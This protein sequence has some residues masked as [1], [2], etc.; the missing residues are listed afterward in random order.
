MANYTF[1]DNSDIVLRK[2]GTNSRSAMD[3]AA[4]IMVE[5]IQEKI[6]YGYHDVHGNPPHTEIVETGR[7]FDSIKA[8][9]RRT[10]QNAYVTEAGTDVPHAIYVHDGHAGHS[11]K[12]K[13]GSWITVKGGHTPGRPF[14]TDGILAAQPELKEILSDELKQGFGK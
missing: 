14:I 1:Q 12:L 4:E 7:L 10:S 6:L 3:K 11:I 9:V 5:S 2:V 13:D 8:Q